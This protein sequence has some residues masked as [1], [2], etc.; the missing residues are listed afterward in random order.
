MPSIEYILRKAHEELEF[1]FVRS[2][3]PGGQNVN[4]VATAAQLRFDVA[5]SAALNQAARA[6][7]A[8]LAGRR[9][10]VE[11]I[12]VIEARRYRTQE[13]NRADALARFDDLLTRALQEP[14]HRVP[15]K[16]SAASREKRLQSKKRKGEIKR[17]RQDRA[18]ET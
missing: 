17:S 6:R 13:Q 8:R 4:K 12:L 7:L 18:H 1:S 11:G 5:R 16:A 9:M 10:T 2:S 15:T 14:R 3:G